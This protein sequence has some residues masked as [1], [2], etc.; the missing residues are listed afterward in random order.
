MSAL[1]PLLRSSSLRHLNLALLVSEKTKP[2]IETPSIAALAKKQ[3]GL[4]VSDGFEGKSDQ[5]FVAHPETGVKRFIFVGVGANTDFAPKAVR[6]A[7]AAAARRANALKLDNLVFDIPAGPA[8]KEV[9]Q[10]VAEGVLLGLYQFTQF[11]SK[12]KPVHLKSVYVLTAPK[13]KAVVQAGL[14]EGRV[15]AEA[16]NLVRDL[17]NTPPSDMDPASL[18]RLAVSL[19]G[20]S[21]QVR[22]FSK[23]E[24]K[25]MNMGG[26]LGVNRGS[27]KDPVFLHLRYRPLRG[28]VKRSIALCGKGITFDSGGLS[29]KPAK[30]METMK[31]DM[32]G[33]ATVLSVIRALSILQLPIEVHGIAPITENM[34]GGDAVKP[35]DVLKTHTGKTIEVLNTDAEGRLVLSDALSY[36]N[37]LKPDE[38]IDIATLT[39][40]CVVALGPKIAG[41]MGNNR[42]LQER[43]EAAAHRAGEKLWPLPLDKEYEPMLKSHVADIKNI[44][45]TGVA[46][47][48]LGG[49]FLKF[50][51]DDKR[52]WAHLDIASTAWADEGTQLSP[53]G[54]T[55]VLVRTLLTYLR[56]YA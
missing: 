22:V 49:L 5:V 7:A 13:D 8:L 52:P 50:F 1:Q 9:V 15:F 17:V 10:A 54:A 21:V 32:A 23:A 56:S 2:A 19:K 51:T 55:G 53:P 3:F 29:L 26:L 35:G 34:P 36:A 40:A 28:A 20:R 6:N 16:V 11:Q 33:A 48:I 46:G 14:Q 42:P 47:T 27:A 39:G 37:R 43:L 30:S 31:D 18:A 38:V 45:P 4:A 12:P 41:L 25:R 24:I 44:G